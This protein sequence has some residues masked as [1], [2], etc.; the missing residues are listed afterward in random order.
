MLNYQSTSS[1][2]CHG[3]R[4]TYVHP[5]IWLNE[6][7]WLYLSQT[8]YTISYLCSVH[9]VYATKSRSRSEL[10]ACLALYLNGR[11]TVCVVHWMTAAV[12]S[13]VVLYCIVWSCEVHVSSACRCNCVLN[14]I[15]QANMTYVLSFC[16]TVDRDRC[17]HD[18][19][20]SVLPEKKQKSLLWLSILIAMTFSSVFVLFYYWQ[21]HWYTVSSEMYE[22]TPE[23]DL[24]CQLRTKLGDYVQMCYQYFLI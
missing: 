13:C 14:K 21:Q 15:C 22:R 8:L 23:H 6:N 19:L 9:L 12:G 16:F 2:Y 1:L 17:V 20:W 11:H 4:R 7:C 10:E 5:V 3:N 18:F 24:W